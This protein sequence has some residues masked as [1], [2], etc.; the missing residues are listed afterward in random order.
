MAFTPLVIYVP[1]ADFRF[2]S[3]RIADVKLPVKTIPAGHLFFE[4]RIVDDLRDY[5]RNSGVHCA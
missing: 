1:A 2:L 5:L 3:I 4:R